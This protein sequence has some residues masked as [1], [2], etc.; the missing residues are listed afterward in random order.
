MKNDS[1]IISEWKELDSVE[2]ILNAIRQHE[3]DIEEYLADIVSALCNVDKESM[4]ND[5]DKMYLS[6]TRWF[7]WYAYKYMTNEPYG[8]IADMSS[9][10]L[11]GRVFSS[12]AVGV[13]INQMDIMIQQND[14]W[15]RRWNIV[16]RIIKLRESESSLLESPIVI[17]VNAPKEIKDNIKINIK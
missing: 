11:N 13:G 12:N 14:V 5:R 6:H 7:F 17:T 9:K 16:K 15:S 10:I 2:K 3:L 4:L 1:S 8:K